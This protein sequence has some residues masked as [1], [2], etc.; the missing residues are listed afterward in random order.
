M[1]AGNKVVAVIVV[2]VVVLVVTLIAVLVLVLVFRFI[3]RNCNS[4]RVMMTR[5]RYCDDDDDTTEY[6]KKIG[7]QKYR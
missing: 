6:H 7:A 4:P 2:L 5:F 3:Y 1:K